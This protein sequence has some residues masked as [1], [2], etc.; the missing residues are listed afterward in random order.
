MIGLVLSICISL[1]NGAEDCDSRQYVI[2]TYR[3][4]EA[5]MAAMDENVQ[6]R[7]DRYLSCQHVDTRYLKRRTPLTASEYLR[8][9]EEAE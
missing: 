8:Q 6:T 9:L 2:D 3:T 4:V 7:P 5:C 1:G